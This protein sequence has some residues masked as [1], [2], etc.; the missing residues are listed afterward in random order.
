[1][2]RMILIFLFPFLFLVSCQ[3]APSE[4]NSLITVSLVESPGI[5]VKENGIHVKPGEDAAF[6]LALSP[7]FSITGVDYEGEYRLENGEEYAS[8]TLCAVSYPVRVKV[9]LSSEYK[10]ITYHANGGVFPGTREGDCLAVSYST[11]VHKRPN[12]LAGVGVPERP[13]YTLLCWNTKS[14]GSGVRVGIGSRV[15][16]EG[17]ALDLYA[18]WEAWTPGE[19]FTTEI[20]TKWDGLAEP[21]AGL[22]IT[23]CQGL[24]EK[25]VIPA[26]IDGTPVRGI[27]RGAFQNQDFTE[28]VL[29]ASLYG[30]EERAFFSCPALR[31]VVLYDNILT[32]HDG[33]FFDCK[34]L[35]TLRINALEAPYGT[36]FRRE[37]AYADKVDL[38][39]Q[40]QGQ[41][42]M[43][44]YSGCSA[45]YNLDSL[46]IKEAFGQ[47]YA[48]VNMAMNG[49]INSF[50]QMEILE[51][52]LEEGDVFIHTPELTSSR[53]LLSDLTMDDGD[54]KLWCGLE[55]NYDLFSLV[56]LRSVS[57]VF[58]SLILYLQ[59][60]DKE[61]SYT[62]YYTDSQGRVYMD[63][64]GGIPF[65][66]EETME[67]LSD[68]VYLDP[69]QLRWTDFSNLTDMYRRYTARGV[70]V[71]LS[72][73]AVN[74]DGVPDEQQ[75]AA[76]EMDKLFHLI[77]RQMRGPVLISSLEDFLYHR[78]DFYDTNYH[79]R[80][81]AAAVNT[82]T[83]IHD[84]RERMGQD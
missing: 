72:Y 78:D 34:A 61:G 41:K 37:S 66:R 33:S 24:S 23:S 9:E 3:K 16:V 65:M 71:L 20:R 22:C 84:I 48:I 18:Q 30:V 57:G 43:V 59:K 50:V 46:L 63:D 77:V 10:Q 64:I 55:Y 39:I 53:Q 42:K 80:S 8:L 76:P 58:D 32:I 75:G 52:F 69:E 28:V 56:D 54:D 44:F 51:Q 79:L 74:L 82:Q 31:E 60:K 12:T 15:T 47:E 70:T 81:G 2:R 38:L 26:E 27:A 17:L 73:A 25:L 21:E 13:G 11:K 4:E 62:D 29:P 40:A 35:Q 5:T 67:Y 19:C 7:G 49:T 36:F 14:D 68:E 45:W 83:W 1:M 6:Y